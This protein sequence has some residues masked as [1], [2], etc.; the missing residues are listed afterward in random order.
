[1]DILGIKLGIFEETDLEDLEKP[2]SIFSHKHGTR[3]IGTMNQETKPSCVGK[4]WN[5]E[6]KDLSSTINGTQS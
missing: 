2:L 3:I 5:I 6:S 4:D 1:L